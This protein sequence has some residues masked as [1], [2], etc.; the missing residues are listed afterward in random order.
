MKSSAK[1]IELA[2]VDDLFSTEE[3]RQDAK[4]E[5]IQE[6]PL[7]ELHP[8]KNHPFKVKDD[9]AMMETADSIK[10]YGVLVP[11]IARPDP[12]GGYELVAGHR[13]HRASELAD[14]ETMPVIV[15]D[16]DDDAAT[17]IMVDSNLQRESL[18]PSER[19][20]AYKMKLDAMKHQGER[21][22][23]TCSQVG[24]K[25][26]GKK[27]SEILAEQVGQSK[28]QIFRYIRLTELI[29]ELMDMVD[30]KKIALNPAY[31]LSFLKKDEQVDLLDAMDSEQATPSLSQAQR[32]KKYSQEGH[33]TLDM[34]RVIMGEEKKSDLDRVTFT[35]DTLRKYFPKSY[36]PQ[37]MQETIIKLLEAWQ[38]KRQ[39]DQER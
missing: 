25:L 6:I 27:S 34:M 15:R 18:L 17:I 33:L 22:D 28:N 9:E 12:E 19:A 14:K 29:P 32:L 7:S 39:R 1:K 10:Q 3:G 23:L 4:L 2:S 8:F 5:K 21:V 26:E 30:E 16:L 24:N 37:R 38:K 35:S 31:E 20:F 11:A 36:T 13:R